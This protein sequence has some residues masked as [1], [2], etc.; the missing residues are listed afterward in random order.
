MSELFTPEE[1]AFIK[2]N[3]KAMS[4]EEMA[5]GIV[6][7]S[8]NERPRHSIKGRMYRLRIRKNVTTYL[9]WSVEEDDYLWEIQKRCSP[10]RITTLIN[11]RFGRNRKRSTIVARLYKLKALHNPKVYHVQP[12]VNVGPISITRRALIQAM[13]YIDETAYTLA[14]RIRKLTGWS[15]T[16]EGVVLMMTVTGMPVRY[17]TPEVKE[18]LNIKEET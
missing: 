14:N 16:E 17:A 1:D 10:D 4:Y 9:F 7:V 11:A 2:L 15:M 5:Q 6:K 13:T 8:G 12:P 3:Y 18:F